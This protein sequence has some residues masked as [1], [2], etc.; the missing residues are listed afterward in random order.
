MFMFSKE[1]SELKNKTYMKLVKR[2]R[3]KPHLGHFNTLDQTHFQ[4]FQTL[5]GIRLHGLSSHPA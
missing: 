5:C 2:K 3:M 1:C 4:P